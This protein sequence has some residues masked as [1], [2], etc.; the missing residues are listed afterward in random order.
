MIG[1]ILAAGLGS[2]LAP[3]TNNLPK[4]L[5]KI[6]NIT[7]L[8]TIIKGMKNSGIEDIIVVT[9]YERQL[10]ID[11]AL[12]THLVTEIYNKD[13][14]TTNNI[15]S[16]MK[17]IENVTNDIIIYE[18]DVVVGDNEFLEL[19]NK[20]DSMLIS[21]YNP[22]IM[23]GSTVNL[24]ENNI[25]TDFGGDGKHSYKTV[26]IYNLSAKSVNKLKKISE[27]ILDSESS[28]NYYESLIKIL[29]DLKIIKLEGII[30]NENSWTEI[31]T[32][33]DLLRLKSITNK[34][35]DKLWGGYWNFDILDFSLIVNSFFPDKNLNDLFSKSSASLLTKYPSTQ[36]YNDTLAKSIYPNSKFDYVTT[37]N[38]SSQLIK[39]LPQLFDDVY[40]VTPTFNEYLSLGYNSLD[41]NSVINIKPSELIN[42]GVNK[43]LFTNPNN[44]YPTYLNIDY[45][46]SL[47][48]SGITVIVDES[49]SDFL[50]KTCL[51][52]RHDN[53]HIIKSLGKTHGNP[54]LRLGLFYTN[55]EF[56]NKKLLS[57]LPVWNICS[58]AQFYLEV[59]P[60]F[61][62]TYL[63]SIKLWVDES[64]F[65]ISELEKLNR[66]TIISD[67]NLPYFL[68]DLGDEDMKLL[69]D[70][71]IIIRDMR[72]KTR[73]Y[74][75]VTS[76]TRENNIKL[77]KVLNYGIQI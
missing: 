24:D 43:I 71:G 27:L 42:S 12:K 72:S 8:T 62:K 77:L 36:K 35:Y 30:I 7:L 6:N 49:F 1:I 47:L 73:N 32:P 65:L 10:V 64:K 46:Q 4:P 34:S 14:S 54:G 44:P 59:F 60:R 69:L 50:D 39:L 33:R 2:R 76:S 37:L 13:F 58:Y 29:C 5:M 40:V 11:E 56:I 74:C 3:L 16:L 31:D 19:V 75:R 55:N 41:F 18:C 68:I 57:L 66:Y 26:N 22:L 52:I 45:I 63:N 20:P 21:K 17:A 61:R 15:V 23:D 53:L 38:G 70:S 9:G 25:V 28:N 67:T 51:D 48:D